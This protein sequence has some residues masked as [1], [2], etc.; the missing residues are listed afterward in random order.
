MEGMRIVMKK[1]FYRPVFIAS[2]LYAAVVC[3]LTQSVALGGEPA[4]SKSFSPSIIFLDAASARKA[5]VDDSL[6]IYFDSLQPM[7]MSA[8]T[9]SEITGATLAEQRAES[10][11]R[12]AAGTLAFTQEEQEAIKWHIEQFSS[13]LA[14]EYPLLGELSWSFLKVSEKIEGGLAHTP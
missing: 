13:K 11:K 4:G 6:E 8:K 3:A 2:F 12:Y 5:I 14:K 9:G 10:K 1:T 7:E